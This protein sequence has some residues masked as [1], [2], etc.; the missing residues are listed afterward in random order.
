MPDDQSF[1]LVATSTFEELERA[2]AALPETENKARGAAFEELVQRFLE[3]DPGIRSGQGI[4]EVWLWAD[5]PERVRH[6]PVEPEGLGVDH[7]IRTTDGSLIAV[8]SKFVSDPSRATRYEE[9]ASFINR[10]TSPGSPFS[11]GLLVSN[12][13]TLAKKVERE[14]AAA[15]NPATGRGIGVVLRDVLAASAI[16]WSPAAPAAPRPPYARRPDQ[17]AAVDDVVRTFADRDRAKLIAACGTGKTLMTHWVARD[18]GAER[19]LVLLPS[20]ALVRQFRTEWAEAANREGWNPTIYAVCSEK[21]RGGADAALLRAD[22]LGVRMVATPDTNPA[23]IA[24]WLRRPGPSIVFSTYQSS[25]RIAEAMADQTI[26]PFDLTVGDEAQNIVTAESTSAFRTVVDGDRIRSRLRLFTTA[27]EKMFSD[28]VKAKAEEQGI[29]VISMD[30][31]T[32]FG[33]L[34]HK[35]S[36][37]TAIENKLITDYQIVVAEIAEEDPELATLIA[38]RRLVGADGV[39][40]I[41]AA[42]LAAGLA[43][44]RAANELGFSRMISFHTRARRGSGAN[45]AA[46]AEAFAELMAGLE[47]SWRVA[48][49]SGEQPTATRAEIVRSALTVT[50]GERGLVTNARCLGEGID[51]PDLEAVAFVDPRSSVIDIVQSAS[52]AL[53]RP[54]T[55]EK[56]VGYIV[57]P[58]VVPAGV[59][60]ET[61]IERDA[62]AQVYRVV[63]AMRGQDERLAE[64]IDA[65]KIGKGTRAAAGRSLGDLIVRTGDLGSRTI[66]LDAWRERIAISV[67]ERTYDSWT[68][69]LAALGRFRA[70]HEHLRV[71]ARH[72]DPSG[73]R[74][75][76]WVSTRRADYAA[77]QLAVERIAAL[78]ALGMVWD[79]LAED[80]ARGIAALKRFRAE[81]GHLRVPVKYIDPSGFR[82]GKWISHRRTEYTAGRLTPER[83]A[84]LEALGMV[85][86]PLAEDV[87]RGLAALERFRAEHGHLRVPNRY[88]DPSGLKLGSWVAERRTEYAAG[89]LA[90]ERIATLEALGMVWDP[91]A[92]DFTRGIATL[93][94]FREKHGHLRVPAKHVDPSGFRLGNWVSNRRA[95]YAAGQLAAERIAALEALGMIWDPLADDA[96]RGLAALER[97]RAEHGHLRVPQNYVDPGGVRLGIWVSTRRTE[98]TAGRLTVERIATLEALGMVW[99]PLAED[100]TR[101][102]TTL[103]AFRE[104]HGHLRV[105]AKHIDPS[106]FRLGNWVSTRRAE[107]A[108]GQLAAERI[109]TLEAL[110]M[111]WDPLADDV[112]RGLA[113]LERFRTEHGHLR[114]PNRYIDPSGFRLGN[115]VSHRRAEYTAGRL[116]VERIAALETLG[117]IW[118]PLGEDFT[119]GLAALGRF[120]A[121]HGH[122]R[123]PAKHVDP[124]GFRLGNWVSNRRTE[125]A[126]GQLAAERIAALEALGMVWDPLADDAARGLAALKRF[127]AEHGHLRVP[128]RYIDPSGFRLGHWVS[129]RRADYAAGQISP[130]RI[131]ALEALG[132]VWSA[133]TKKS[134]R[135]P[136]QRRRAARWAGVRTRFGGRSPS[137]RQLSTISSGAI[138]ARPAPTS[139][140]M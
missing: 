54:K 37:A 85:W 34:A 30:D 110:G 42:T 28:R 41:D 48:F 125:Y 121:E 64:E 136:V 135:N 66:D 88:I 94:A 53:R 130:E 133:R 71:P 114:V 39:P 118:D 47:P 116:A 138:P 80:F 95:E 79:P 22:E 98:Y 45:Q 18:L 97:F 55:I 112:A 51:L 124:S 92:E 132:M 113:A 140:M 120:R 52:R 62:Y 49:V 107:Y 101:G 63:R 96:A 12:A 103:E 72:V 5:W 69:H 100:F 129:R 13:F 2:I 29:E 27:T 137:A 89:R 32:Q 105:S 6:Y 109:V 73:F 36:F 122:L 78:E 40:T 67:V 35:I 59:D 84:T 102:I 70:E 57:I 131:A 123:V 3:R 106:G 65:L 119:R 16:D 60:L 86:D 117:M 58:V 111:V 83:I 7:I 25:P 11:G 108:A 46:G 19:I 68:T 61:A 127:R 139:V 74:I 104:E 14:F 4:A 81:H 15:H 1:S 31:E 90:V 91:L 76:N 20:L 75:G 87:A 10:V 24:D 77:G 43:F 50:P 115:W 99:D 128:Q 44:A 82:L 8:Q 17:I 33:P 38:E 134:D 21:D 9:L 56:L 26:P 23:V 126:A 93:E